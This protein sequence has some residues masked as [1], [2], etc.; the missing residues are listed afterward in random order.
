MSSWQV[1]GTPCQAQSIWEPHRVSVPDIEIWIP[2]HSGHTVYI[3]VQ[4]DAL[5]QPVRIVSV[6]VSGWKTRN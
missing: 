4:S 5:A 2:H 1:A 6:K 3:R